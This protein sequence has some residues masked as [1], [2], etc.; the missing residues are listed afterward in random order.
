MSNERIG[1]SCGQAVAVAK[2]L[3][4]GRINEKR[5]VT[6]RRTVT[7]HTGEATFPHDTGNGAVGRELDDLD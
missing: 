7:G 1:L 3:L 5:T 2:A 4:D 6:S